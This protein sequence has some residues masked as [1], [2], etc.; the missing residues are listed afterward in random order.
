M[1]K[2]RFLLFFLYFITLSLKAQAEERKIGII[3]LNASHA[4]F[5]EGNR[6]AG[7]LLQSA[8]TRRVLKL[9]GDQSPALDLASA[10]NTS[11]DLNNLT[12]EFK[13]PLHFTN[14]NVITLQDLLFSLKR[15]GVDSA[16]YSLHRHETSP[17]N[18]SLEVRTE[19]GHLPDFLWSC[20][21]LDRKSTLL[22][23]ADFGKGTNVVGAGPYSIRD[24]RRGRN[25]ILDIQ[26]LKSPAVSQLCPA[27]IHL[28]SMENEERALA[29]LR[30]GEIDLF[31]AQNQEVMAE[32]GKDETLL[33]Q[34]CSIN[35]VVHRRG[36]RLRCDPYMDLLHLNYDYELSSYR[37]LTT[38]LNEED[39]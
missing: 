39:N 11:P 32:V 36:L 8:L 27:R 34:K 24:I 26:R 2:R 17:A 29:A 22:F 38:N 1:M 31:L 6:P 35:N 15:C 23:G 10:Y 5:D 30:S 13:G 14:G 3:G 4:N 33:L 21:I 28:L 7:F 9:N 25:L 19:Q 18:F 37:K 12:F 20:P 16:F